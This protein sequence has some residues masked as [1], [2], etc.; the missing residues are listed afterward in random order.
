MNKV[1]IVSHSYVLEFFKKLNH[2]KQ[3]L[4]PRVSK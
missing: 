1:R 3:I 4:I 2:I